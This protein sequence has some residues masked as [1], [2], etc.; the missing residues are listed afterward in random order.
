MGP[1]HCVSS[2]IL[3]LVL[4]ALV[5]AAPPVARPPLAEREAVPGKLRV[6][7]FDVSLPGPGAAVSCWLYTTDGFRAVGQKEMVVSVRRR[8]DEAVAAFPEDPIALFATLFPLASRGQL[9]TEGGRTEFG[10]ARFLGRDDIRGMLYTRPDPLRSALLQPSALVLVPVTESELHS[11]E[12][13]GHLRILGLLGAQQRLFP[14]PGYFD[15]DRASVAPA[16]EEW[17]T[18][19]RRTALVRVPGVRVAAEMP[20]SM[21][22][23]VG[24]G[25][26]LLSFPA[27]SREA[28]EEAVVRRGAESGVALLAELDPEADALAVYRSGQKGPVAT[29]AGDGPVSRMAGTFVLFAPGT[30]GDTAKLYEDGFA[31]VLGE[32]SRRALAQ[33]LVTGKDLQLLGDPGSMAIRIHW[34]D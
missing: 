25:N 17:D 30:G 8:A 31:V 7:V 22:P 34:R 19:L 29:R 27:T 16:P 14:W 33:A 2:I 10:G 12:Q 9:V 23:T 18:V 28:I 1:R 11:A 32:P 13:F 15:R 5:A 24:Q 20:A 26:L 3:G 4:P 6:R 21:S